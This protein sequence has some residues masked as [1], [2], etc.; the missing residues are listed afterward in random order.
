MLGA[1]SQLL[2][3]P[4]EDLRLTQSMVGGKY[5]GKVRKRPVFVPV[6][7]NKWSLYQDRLGTSIGKVETKRRFRNRILMSQS[8]E[9]LFSAGLT[10]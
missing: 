9:R 7:T 10:G 3:L 6:Y 5:G 8:T 1:V 2:D 4:V